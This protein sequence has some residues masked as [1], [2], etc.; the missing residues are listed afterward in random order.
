VELLVVITILTILVSLILPSMRTARNLAEMLKCTSNIRQFGTACNVYAA[1]AHEYPTAQPYADRA[2]NCGQDG[3]QVPLL[4]NG[5]YM[6]LSVGMC[7]AERVVV[8]GWYN[9]WAFGYAW[10]FTNPVM[11]SN[12][13][14]FIN[15]KLYMNYIYF[16]PRS[17]VDPYGQPYPLIDSY[18]GDAFQVDH[19]PN[20][21]DPT[22]YAQVLYSPTVGAAVSANRRTDGTNGTPGFSNMLWTCFKSGDNGV[23]AVCGNPYYVDRSVTYRGSFSHANILSATTG[24]TFTGAEWRNMLTA[25]GSA[26]Q[27]GHQ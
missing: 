6:P 23:L 19:I 16:G 1:D 9:N 8:G 11:S 13:G 26:T 17:N 7:Q 12:T 25:D 18:F 24:G 14:T 21:P 22:A 15:S 2:H 20:G 3:S 27:V 4:V 10:D 5:G